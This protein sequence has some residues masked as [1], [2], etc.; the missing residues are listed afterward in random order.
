MNKTK[1]YLFDVD[2]VL[3]NR[4]E[5]ISIDFKN[6][7]LEF[8]KD[9][10]YFLV[11]GSD[12]EKATSQIGSE[13]IENASVT[14][15]C[16]GNVIYIDQQEI[17]INKLVLH[18]DEIRWLE[19]KINN[20][21]F[22]TK[23]GNHIVNRKGTV[24]FSVLGRPADKTQRERYI[25][26]DDLTNERFNIAT[27]LMKEFPRLEAFIGGDTS[28]DICCRGANKR[29]IMQFVSRSD[30]QLL[31]FTDRYDA[32]KLHIDSP[33]V[34]CIEPHCLHKIDNGYQQTWEILKKI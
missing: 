31:F 21:R 13:L 24:S 18:D 34:P 27:E 5:P 7:L 30:N 15:F 26:Y 14:F 1:S 2:G 6:Y 9:K 33:L 10:E 8:L 12:R 28:I 19:D 22:D 3:C 20:S 29:Q 25:K 32:K 11:T 23:L 4:G 17:F 16:M